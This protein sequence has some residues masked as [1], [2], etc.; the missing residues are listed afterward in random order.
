MINGKARSG[1]DT[2]ADYIVNKTGA[3]KLWF[4]K[5]LKDMCIKYFG[6][7]Y[8]ECYDHKTEFSRRVLQAVGQMFRE[9]FGKN[10]W[11]DKVVE[12]LKDSINDGN[13][14]F[15]ISDCRYRNEIVEL[16]AAYDQEKYTNIVKCFNEEL[17]KEYQ[18]EYYGS[19]NNLPDSFFNA[20]LSQIGCTTIKITRNNCPNIEYG[21][22]HA[23]ENDLNSFRFEHLIENNGSLEDLYKMVDNLIYNLF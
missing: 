16:C 2:I 15:I 4:A 20:S 19:I 13:K 17:W 12:Q 1:K 3:K 9:E 6:L 7:T 23:S 5:P 8:D 18:L 14:H 10:F 11:V 22:E 21:A